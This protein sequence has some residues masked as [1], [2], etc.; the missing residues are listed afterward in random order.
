MRDG[1]R[2][3]TF[4]FLPERGGLRFPVIL[5][6]TPYGIAAAGTGDEFDHA[7]AWL[8]STAEPMR[9]SILRGWK[10]IVAHGYAAVYQD[11]RGRHGS[12]G[13]DRVYADD[14]SDGYDTLDWIAG[15]DWCSQRVGMSGSSAGAA[16]TFAAASTRHPNLRAFFASVDASVGAREIFK[17][18]IARSQVLTSV[19]PLLRPMICRGP[20]WEFAD[21]IQITAT[22][23]K[24]SVKNWLADPVSH[25]LCAILSF[26][27]PYASD[28]SCR[29]CVTSP[30]LEPGKPLL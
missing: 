19:R 24:R 21:R 3:N 8:P 14:A 5:H 30:R 2:L 22:R 6:R 18:C 17:F 16:T 26:R 4:V 12:E 13:E 28:A 25:R 7:N 10:S 11:C 9:G 29:K 23:S 1:I 15:Q 20:V 27:P